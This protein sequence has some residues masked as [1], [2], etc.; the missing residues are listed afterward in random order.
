MNN[1]KVFDSKFFGEHKDQKV[2]DLWNAY[3]QITTGVA[4][5]MFVTMRVCFIKWNKEL[6][7]VSLLGDADDKSFDRAKKY[8]TEYYP[9]YLKR[10]KEIESLL[11]FEE[12]KE[13]EQ[14]VEE[15]A[16]KSVRELMNGE[17]V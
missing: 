1:E 5:E 15:S 10:I 9:V 11:S 13:A 2:K 6:E 16:G 12:L 7:K 14:K 8:F 17:K 3:Q 4:A